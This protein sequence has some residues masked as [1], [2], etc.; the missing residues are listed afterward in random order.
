VRVTIEPVR[1]ADP[2]HPHLW[3]CLARS[4]PE[5][6]RAPSLATVDA[7][8]ASGALAADDP[9]LGQLEAVRRRLPRPHL[10][11]TSRP[12]SGRCPIHGPR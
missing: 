9:V 8:I 5:L 1:D 10:R 3:R 12:G 6:D 7:L 2:A 11:Q 4:D